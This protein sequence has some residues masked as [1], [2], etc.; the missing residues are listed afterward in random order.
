[1]PVKG[2]VE[3]RRDTGE[4]VIGG[5]DVVKRRVSFPMYQ[6]RT[7]RTVDVHDRSTSSELCRGR[8]RS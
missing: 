2:S 7:G 4:V 5:K 8:S 3:D 6:L 1:M